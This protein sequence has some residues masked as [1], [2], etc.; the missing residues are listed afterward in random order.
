[1]ML[2]WMRIGFWI[3]FVGG[4]IGILGTI[5]G[6]WAFYQTRETKLINYARHTHTVFSD[7]NY[8]RA[9][10]RVAEYNK[11]DTSWFSETAIV[12]WNSGTTTIREADVRVP[13]TIDMGKVGYIVGIKVVDAKSSVPNN[14]SISDFDASK[15]TPQSATIRFKL[16]DPGMA[17][18]IALLH[19]GNGRAISIGAELGPG[20][21]IREF[22]WRANKYFTY[23]VV[24]IVAGLIAVTIFLIYKRY[25]I[26]RL[27]GGALTVSRWLV[28]LV[29][30][31]IGMAS[32]F[33]ADR[34]VEVFT[35]GP[36]LSVYPPFG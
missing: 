33:V 21:Q 9:S 24:I 10:F 16:F 14:F 19:Q 8:F 23:G 27:Q 20:F 35:R 30:F 25:V 18:K 6:I 5:F 15:M 12:L 2:N 7:P 26:P 13:I 1:M 4:V 11:E 29:I 34:I 28:D 22:D 32:V 3:S 31:A 17:V 36:P